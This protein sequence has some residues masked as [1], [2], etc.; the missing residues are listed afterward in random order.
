MLK[1]YIQEQRQKKIREYQ[2]DYLIA[3]ILITKEVPEKLLKNLRIKT[4]NV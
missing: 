1:D 3:E 2:I 4:Y